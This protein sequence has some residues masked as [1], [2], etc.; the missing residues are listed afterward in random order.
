MTALINTFIHKTLYKMSFQ[1]VNEL[2]N[3]SRHRRRKTGDPGNP[4][5]HNLTLYQ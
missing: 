1:R 4:L 5:Q 3:G 2:T